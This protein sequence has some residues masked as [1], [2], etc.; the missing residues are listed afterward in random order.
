M[1]NI[2]LTFLTCICASPWT[3]AEFFSRG[4]KRCFAYKRR[5]AYP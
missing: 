5:F 4:H 3:S 2:F 1:K